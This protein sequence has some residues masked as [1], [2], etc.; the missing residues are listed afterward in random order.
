MVK[1]IIKRYMPDEQTLRNKRSLKLIAPLLRNRRLW[2]FNRHCIARAFAIGLFCAF[3]PIPFQ[4]LLAAILAVCF[5]ANVPLS[6]GLVWISNPFT[7]PPIFYFCY[8]VGTLILQQQIHAFKFELTI[9]WFIE[10]IALIWKPLLLG[11]FLSGGIAAIISFVLVH[12]LW[13][14][15]ILH[16]WRQRCLARQSGIKS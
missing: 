12:Q 13:R 16:Q 7:I 3:M 11:C 10:H 9:K 15:H 5:S 8:K 2:H 6:I 1:R 4:M 14:R